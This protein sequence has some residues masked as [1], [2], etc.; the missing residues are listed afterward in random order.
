MPLVQSGRV[1]GMPSQHGCHSLF[2]PSADLYIKLLQA[3]GLASM[4]LR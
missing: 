1:K 4:L 2:L 3:A